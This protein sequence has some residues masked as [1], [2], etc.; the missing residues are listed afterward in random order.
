MEPGIVQFYKV[1]LVGVAQPVSVGVAGQVGRGIG[2]DF[3]DCDG[4]VGFA[5]GKWLVISGR[6]NSL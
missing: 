1:L 6:Y 2:K 5:W 3:A 4:I